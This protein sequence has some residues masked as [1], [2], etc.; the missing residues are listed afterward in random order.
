VSSKEQQN[1]MLVPGFTAKASLHGAIEEYH[2]VMRTYMTKDSEYAIR[3][4]RTPEE[5]ARVCRR[6]ARFDRDCCVRFF[7]NGTCSAS[8]CDVV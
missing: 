4:S 1:S 7:T 2:E 6:C 3:L 5:C 8:C